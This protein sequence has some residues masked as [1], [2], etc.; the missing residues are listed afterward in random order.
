MEYFFLAIRHRL[1]KFQVFKYYYSKLDAF[2]EFLNEVKENQKLRIYTLINCATLLMCFAIYVVIQITGQVQIRDSLFENR[3]I[4]LNLSNSEIFMGKLLPQVP[5]EEQLATNQTD[6]PSPPTPVI[7]STSVDIAIAKSIPVAVQFRARTLSAQEQA[8]SKI[9][10]II[11]N[12]GLNRDLLLQSFQLS[13]GFTIGFSPYAIDLGVW[14]DKA[15]S[16]GFECFSSLPME[17]SNYLVN[18]PGPLA[19]ISKQ[20]VSENIS[21]L[22]R[23]I[24][25]SYK[26]VGFYSSPDEVLS[27]DRNNIA[28]ILEKLSAE[29][30]I[31]INSNISNAD[32]L[33]SFAEPYR[34][35]IRTVDAILDSTINRSSILARLAELQANAEHNGSAIGI[36]EVSPLALEVLADWESKLDR[37]RFILTPVSTLF[38]KR[39]P[40]S[41]VESS[42]QPS[43]HS[44][45]DAENKKSYITDE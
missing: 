30:M 12:Q 39:V 13:R 7:D 24:V 5:S 33:R 38:P 26:S 14:I 22:E 45:V 20:P 6:A 25:Q 15:H 9:A 28:P 11:A 23:I 40:R 42:I 43:M 29:D 41:A 8:K 19:L 35:E 1:S 17:P 27:S 21:L 37:N 34:L 32:N 10:I 44:T 31:F 3:L 18:D 2:Y 36:I 16:Y 4:V